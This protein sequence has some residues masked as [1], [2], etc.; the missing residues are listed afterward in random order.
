MHWHDTP[1]WLQN[2]WLWFQWKNH[3]GCIKI[4]VKF[5]WKHLIYFSWDHNDSDEFVMISVKVKKK[6]KKS[7]T[8]SKIG[9]FQSHIFILS[10]FKA[11]PYSTQTINN[12]GWIYWQVYK[13]NVNNNGSDNSKHILIT[14]LT[15]YARHCAYS[16]A[17]ISFHTKTTPEISSLFF[18]SWQVGKQGLRKG[19]ICSRTYMVKCSKKMSLTTGLILHCQLHKFKFLHFRIPT[20]GCHTNWVY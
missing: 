13:R 4:S 15:Y 2:I 14:M 10:L 18:P 12:Q 19:A 16:T 7:N 3:N 17:I 20:S 1:W 9:F 8:T 6:L 11:F 5:Q